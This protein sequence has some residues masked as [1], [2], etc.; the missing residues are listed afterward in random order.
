MVGIF[1]NENGGIRYASLIVN[2]LKPVET[3]SRNMLGKLLG[4]RVAIVRTCR[5]KNP[6]VIGYATIDR[7]EWYCQKICNSEEMRKYTC[8]PEGS[9]YDAG[10]KGKWF[11]WMKDPEVCEPYPLP[12]NAV[13]HGRSWCEF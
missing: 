3:R 2:G 13:R 4:Y 8:I 12:E 1:V 5:G 6:V 7:A 11:Y 10:P 9:A